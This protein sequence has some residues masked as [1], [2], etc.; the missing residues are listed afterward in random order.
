QRVVA[1][2]AVDSLGRLQIVRALELDPGDVFD[3]IHQSIDRDELAAA[4]IDW[5]E[6][7][8]LEDRLRAFET[9]IDVH[10]TSRLMAV[11][12]DLDLMF[13][14]QLGLDH[15]PADGRRRLLAAPVVSPERAIDVVKA[16]DSR[17]H[18]EV[19]A[20]MAAHPF[21]EKLFP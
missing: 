21:A 18:A 15:F 19:F 8:A 20:K 13:A 5:F 6:D 10:E 9:I 1:V 2:A 17:G 3:H 7:V 14:R 12:P 16:R 4:Q 11:T